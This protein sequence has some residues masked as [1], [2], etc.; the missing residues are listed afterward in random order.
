MQLVENY[1]DLLFEK[2][3][4]KSLF[5]WC[6]KFT[7]GYEIIAWFYVIKKL[8]NSLIIILTKR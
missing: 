4:N 5:S 1:K 8:K 2:K 3:I 7:F 6:L